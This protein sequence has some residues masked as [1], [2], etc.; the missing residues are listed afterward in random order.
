MTFRTEFGSMLIYLD[1]YKWNIYIRFL[2]MVLLV[3][4]PAILYSFFRI[5]I[6]KLKLTS[7]KYIVWIMVFALYPFVFLYVDAPMTLA[8]VDIMPG[9]LS[10]IGMAI[11]IL[12]VLTNP[13]PIFKINTNSSAWKNNVSPEWIVIIIFMM[14]AVYMAMQLKIGYANNAIGFKSGFWLGIQSI[15]LTLVYYIFY[16]INHYFLVNKI[17][18]TKGLIYYIFSF[19]AMVCIFLGPLALIYYY[20]PAFRDILQYKVTESWIG[21][22]APSGFWSIYLQSITFL[23]IATIPIT[24]LVQWIGMAKK[25]NA[26]EKE[27]TDAEL[28]LLK[29]QINPHFFFNTLNNIYSMS[30]KNSEDTP[31]AILQLSDLMRYVIYKGQEKTLPLSAE[32]KYIED[33]I[34]LQKLRLHQN[35]DFKFDVNIKSTDTPVTPLLFIILVENAFKHGIETASDDS[36]LHLHLDQND[37]GITFSCSNSIEENDTNTEPG[38]GLINLKRRLELSYS[39]RHNL[40]IQ[41]SD[42]DYQVIL[43]IDS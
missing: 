22:N 21:P 14:F 11:L 19:L 18:R 35:F 26:L 4:S 31:E 32:I 41:K 8:S 2:G 42:S 40:D 10:M 20:M 6:D 15:L 30:R 38:L 28:N 33:Y 7:I 39:G 29:Q 36:Y 3:F 27:R 23:M 1:S 16:R 17:Y 5:H 24:I 43:S 25:V 9:I 13:T 34:D 37:N 12:E